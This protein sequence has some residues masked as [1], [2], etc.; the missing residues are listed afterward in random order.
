MKNT[1]L[2][3][4][5]CLTIIFGVGCCDCELP[6]DEELR[7]EIIGTW[8]QEE[9]KY[10]I[11]DPNDIT[12]TANLLDRMT[13]NADG[14]ITEGGLYAYCCTADCDTA[15]QGA[16]SWI[17][18]NG[19][20]TIIPDKI[21]YSSHLNQAYPINCLDEDILVFDNVVISGLNRKKTC[22]CRQ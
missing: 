16:C 20:L 17:I 15:N 22:F 7:Q 19:E 2:F 8:K 13:F 11:T 10:P 1:F 6:S 12:E 21:A 4:I 18:E 3:L 9:C 5:I 14:S